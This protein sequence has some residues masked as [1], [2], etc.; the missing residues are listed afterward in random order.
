[1]TS[2]FVLVYEEK[3]KKRIERG[4]RQRDRQTDIEEGLQ[5]IVFNEYFQYNQ[6]Y[7]G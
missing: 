6:K 7:S 5:P 1:M 2:N 3:A 4:E